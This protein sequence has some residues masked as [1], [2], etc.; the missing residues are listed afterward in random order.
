[1]RLEWPK[2]SQQCSE[3]EVGGENDN[4]S[5]YLFKSGVNVV[6]VSEKNDNSNIIQK[7]PFSLTINHGCRGHTMSI[8]CGGGSGER[9]LLLKHNILPSLQ[10]WYSFRKYY[11]I[12]VPSAFFFSW[13]VVFLF[14]LHWEL[15]SRTAIVIQRQESSF[16]RINIHGSS[17]KLF[18]SFS[19]NGN[20]LLI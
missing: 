8:F 16:Y 18:H 19:H 14:H 2:S 12:S 9:A 11:S 7:Y 13:I 17:R 15:W 20:L 4:L 5:V 10:T 3:A 1:M 6:E